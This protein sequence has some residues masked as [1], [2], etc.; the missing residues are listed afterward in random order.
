MKMSSRILGPEGDAHGTAE[1]AARMEKRAGTQPLAHEVTV[2]VHLLQILLFTGHLQSKPC[3]SLHIHHLYLHKQDPGP[4]LP[5]G[6]AD[7]I[8]KNDEERNTFLARVVEL[9]HISLIFNTSPASS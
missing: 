3:C 8:Q 5:H 9:F 6:R 4:D 2:D 1:T 7:T